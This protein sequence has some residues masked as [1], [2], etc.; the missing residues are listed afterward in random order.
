MYKKEQY[1]ALK[2]SH[3]KDDLDSRNPK[4]SALRILHLHY[5][6]E[7]P[8]LLKLSPSAAEKLIGYSVEESILGEYDDLLLMNLRRFCCF[9]KHSIKMH[10]RKITFWVSW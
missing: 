1:I 7:D 9:F 2:D 8:L 6:S 10:A 4:A 3:D 5:S